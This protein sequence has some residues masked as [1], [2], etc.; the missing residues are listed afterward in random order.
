MYTDAQI[1]Q[2]MVALGIEKGDIAHARVDARA[3]EVLKRRVK[4]QYR[5]L[6]L[7][8]HPDRRGGEED[9]APLL[10]LAQ[11]VVR[12]VGNMRV[13]RNPRR[14]KWAVKIKTAVVTG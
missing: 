11:Q 1:C 3:L 14:V 13:L 2:V 12:E 4:K 8:W 10:S 7:E 9:K 5:K 6:A